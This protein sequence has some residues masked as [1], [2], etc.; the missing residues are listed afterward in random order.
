MR[1]AQSGTSTGTEAF[2]LLPIS[3]AASIRD[4]L[5]DYLGTTFALADPD[6]RYALDEFLQ[7]PETGLFR[8]PYVRLRLPFRPADPGWRDS[9][10]WYE[11]FTPYGHQ[12]A[13]FERLSSFNLTA[14]KPRPLPTLVTTGTGSGKTESFLYPIL[15]HVQRAKRQGITG[16]KAI[17]LYP[18]NAL[19]ND[20]ASRLASI[21]VCNEPISGVTAALYT[22]QEG[23]ER[24]K[25]SADGLIA[26]RDIIRDCAPDILLTNYKML[27]QL[28]LRHADAGIWRQS[29][30]SLQ[31]LV[32]DEFHTYD[33]A[34]GTDVSMLLRRLG[35]TL[36]SYWNAADQSLTEEDWRRPLGRITPIA[37]SATLGDKGDPRTMLDFAE[38]VFG[39]PFDQSAVVT[40]S[41]FGIDE[42]AA[43]APPPWPPNDVDASVISG[44]V[45]RVRAL[46]KPTPPAAIAVEVLAALYD[47]APREAIEDADAEALLN[48]AKQHPLV[49][50]V[51]SASGDAMSLAD[52]AAETV[53][54]RE[55]AVARPAD[56]EAFF[57]AV[58]GMLSHLRKECGREA[59]SLEAHLWIRELTRVG[60]EA[61]G[62][63][64][65]IWEDDGIV[66]DASGHALPT[67]PAIY[68]R[69][70]HRSGWGVILAPTG[71]E[72]DSSD[73]A[74]RTKHMKGD[75][76]FRPLIYAPADGDREPEAGE[77][78]NLM[79]FDV[80]A[81]QLVSA[82]GGGEESV[83]LPVLTH[84]GDNA[85][86]LSK[87]D[88]CPSCL[89][90][91]GIRF[92]GSA[93]A[94]MLSVSLSGLFGTPGLDPRE[95]KALVFTDSVQDAAHRA[96][97]VQARSHA[98]TLRS[99]VRQA[100]GDDDID[101]AKLAAR[102]VDL[103][104]DDQS[105]RYRVLPPEL[106]ARE[107]FEKFWSTPTLRQVPR[108]VRGWV[109]KRLL[110]DIELEFGLRSNVGRTLEL[111]G[112]A[113]AELDANPG[114][115]TR[116]ARSAWE[117]AAGTQSSI[118]NT[119]DD[120]LLRWVVGVIE[121]MRTRG[122][123]DHEWF[124]KFRQEDGNR[125]WITGGRKRQE[126]MPGFG[127]GSSTPGFPV[128][129]KRGSGD[130]DL[131]PVAS[132]RGWYAAWTKKVLGLDTANDG[133]TLA[134][135][136]FE[137]L[138]D[139]GVIGTVT[140]KT[141][142]TTYHL[143]PRALIVR[144]VVPDEMAGGE[145]AL[146]CDD[147]HAVTVAA[148]DAVARLVGGPCF[149]PR[150]A[151][152]QRAFPLQ[153]NFYRQM[154]ESSDIQRVVAREHTSLLEDKVRLEY[155]N[156]F[157]AR[158]PA[159]NAPNV[160]V[161][162]PT[163][164]MG[165]DIG[166]LSA[167]MLASVPKTVANYLQRVGRAGR[168]TG[169]A[170]NLAFVTARGDQLPRFYRPLDIINGAVRPPATYLDA[171]EI[172][173]RQFVASVADRL[174]RDK[175]M[176]HP[177]NTVEAL[178][179]TV[180]GTYLGT[181]IHEAET[182]PALIDAFV[183]GFSSLDR[184]VVKRLREWAT[185]GGGLADRC[186]QASLAWSKRLETLGHRRT[187]VQGVL[188]ALQEKANSAAATED[189]RR[190]YR[191]ALAALNLT[192]RQISDL[193]SEYWIST[194]ETFGL[195][196]NYTLLDDSVTLAVSVSW[197]DPETQ[198]YDDTSFELSRG[199]AAALRD[200]APGSTFYANGFAIAIDA[201]D[202]GVEGEA[203][204]AWACC[205]DCGFIDEEA[206]PAKCP[207]CEATGIA[208]VGQRIPV[209]ELTAVSSAIRR[210]EATIDDVRDERT[211]E[212]FDIVFAADIDGA[213][214]SRTWYANDVGLGAKH[215]RGL[216]LRWLNI[217]KTH[218][219]G[220]SRFISGDEW[221]A[222]MFRLCSE[223]GKLDLATGSN[224]PREH[225]PWCS[226]RTAQNEKTVSIALGRKM[227]TEGLVMRLPIEWTVGADP[228]AIPSMTAAL[229]LGLQQHIGG[230]PDHLQ[231]QPIRDPDSGARA[232]LIHDIVPGGT[233]YLAELANPEI[234]W[235]IL[236][237]ALDV[238][239]ACPCQDD[240]KLACD[241]CLLP[242]AS[243]HQ[244]KYTD[245]AYAEN[246]L[247]E[248]LG[249]PTTMTWN[250]KEEWPDTKSHESTLELEFRRV[251]EERLK[252]LGATI[253][254]FWTGS[255]IAWNFSL[256]AGREW[257]LQPQ[258][259][260]SGCKPDFVLRSKKPGV[261]PV[262]I[263]TDGF[264]FHASITNNRL[265]DD[266]EK[267]QNLRGQ[268]YFVMAFT[269]D[270][271]KEAKPPS[272]YSAQT[273]S[274]V[275]AAAG[276]KLSAKAVDL[277]PRGP[278]ES[279]LAWIQA[280]SADERRDLAHWVPFFL[281][282][283]GVT[284]LPMRSD[285]HLA[286]VG[287]DV[288]DGGAPAAGDAVATVWRRDRLAVVLRHVDQATFTFA[289][290]VVLDD[291]EAGPDGKASW[292][293]WLWLSNLLSLRQAETVIT[294][295]NHMKL[296][297]VVVPE[298]ENADGAT[299]VE[300][301]LLARID[302]LKLPKP[303]VGAEVEGIMTSIA[304]PEYKIAVDLEL[305]DE[306][307]TDLVD[308]GWRL[309]AAEASEISAVI[310]KVSS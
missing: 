244:V 242:F 277:I 287:L 208:D 127:K 28:L 194:L 234:V 173:R 154:Y 72:L 217:G 224:S 165:I 262:A 304:W 89:R 254:P 70:C 12:A 134:R 17:I 184:D 139:R 186:H 41:R 37:T 48:L 159:P 245:R 29:A 136:L 294:T 66:A 10:E 120:L 27:D 119:T 150:C 250:L 3:Q 106:A 82:C 149:V 310:G 225:R 180:A 6:A 235:T 166:D 7:H 256:G 247:R 115:L 35:L 198:S 110:L 46:Q 31:Y 195:F 102:V 117:A 279:L 116:C 9:L 286:Q 142:A 223:C 58:L 141:G 53:N 24:S 309:V 145:V 133:A 36:K 26:S 289:T 285:A 140:S 144:A 199:S 69:H 54:P 239:A 16:T 135:L 73:D 240:G 257:T 123:I 64:R 272:W 280:P 52:L 74:I 188:P 215:I 114:L 59:V 204:R 282:P 267:R 125:W 190:E 220:T 212:R 192:N 88:T 230:A 196:P 168:I 189:D 206:S 15:D 201:V 161:A 228:F 298:A 241:K 137:Q 172:L 20:Q 62:S 75:E 100:I 248:L 121:R 148:P 261:P 56:V 288:L 60:R 131:E 232:L 158:N 293:E 1:Q 255:G 271:L 71:W 143:D 23:P 183:G 90:A 295:R 85:G 236:R 302:E 185:P 42:W 216:T 49:Q 80:D 219:P 273:V 175:D 211:R 291:A 97:F 170:F 98:L 308:L 260:I 284:Q 202:L 124:A 61:A 8:G 126:G 156:Q 14:D 274:P 39:E 191:T 203:M 147:C 178:S 155:E 200:F 303:T 174:A 87:K 21:I 2:E 281:V 214:T 171:E 157:K 67:F 292:Q 259:N 237:L 243:L 300:A 270:D 299:E 181:L 38:T 193:R 275:L 221:N 99:L 266:A 109:E 130:T 207:R 108:Q 146:Q 205:P 153:D 179:S 94:T 306:D 246:R 151:G 92:L 264:D 307:R 93:I 182:N 45:H 163:L 213:G 65:L 111:S 55:I 129:G 34:Q 231:V 238:V 122:A 253:E 25:V 252:T 218:A 101:L 22:G 226:L 265:W 177:R 68:C 76:R 32:L 5:L 210:E 187:Q 19:A 132:V 13:A 57:E 51:V 118:I 138:A 167:V 169:N 162:T 297:S 229:L 268:G 77:D 79:W 290:A 78:S 47:S 233:G 91:E 83:V 43:G 104:G 95:K 18:M 112:S 251:L 263:F 63:P 128:A 86:D 296:G 222:A 305:Y 50:A 164:E 227:V 269:W 301:R 276:D 197:M 160:L 44:V 84:K 11:G 40:E 152:L 103:A 33:G 81:R 249:A 283:D 30:H 113:V 278:M 4:S 107:K 96:G 209:V 258:Q 105:K 176:P